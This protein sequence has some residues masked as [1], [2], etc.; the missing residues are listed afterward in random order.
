VRESARA[1]YI[2]NVIQGEGDFEPG[3]DNKIEITVLGLSTPFTNQATDS[4]K[5]SS[6][7]LVGG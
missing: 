1:I 2:E 6:F 4:F 7:N 3:F 5:V